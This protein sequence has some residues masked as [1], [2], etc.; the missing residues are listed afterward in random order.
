MSSETKEKDS[1]FVNTDGGILVDNSEAEGELF[2][3]SEG[4]DPD[5]E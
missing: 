3:L 4:D 1:R 2:D 5:E